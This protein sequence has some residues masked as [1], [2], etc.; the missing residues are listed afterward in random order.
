MLQVCKVTNSAEW[1]NAEWEDLVAIEPG[2]GRLYADVRRIRDPG[3]GC[4]CVE[5]LW[6]RQL[7]ARLAFLV[8]FRARNTRLR[9]M[10]AY[11]V[12]FEKIYNAMP[13]CRGCACFA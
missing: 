11:D 13:P 4:F 7:K 12:A 9:S 10:A 3:I 6:Q 1:S 2:L 8:G 5:A